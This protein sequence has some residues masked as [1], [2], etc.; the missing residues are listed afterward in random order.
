VFADL[1]SKLEN[2]FR[3]LAG[4]AAINEKN[5]A[6]ALD[7][8]RVA[9]LEADV[10]YGVVDAIITRAKEKALGQEVLRSVSPGQ[11][12]VKVL[13]DE[14]VAAF[15]GSSASVNLEGP[16]P[17]VVMVVGLQGSGK[18]TF[19][20]KLANYLT[21]KG[22]RPLL[23]AA[24]VYRP[25]AVEQLQVLGRSL[26]V[27]T[28]SP[29]EAASGDPVQICSEAVR[30][31]GRHGLDTLVLDT[32]GRLHIDDH[33]MKELD[34]IRERT[35]PQ[36]ILFVA[37]AMTGQ[38]AVVTAKTF[39]ERLKFDG[40]VLTKLDG[41]ARGGAALSIHAVTGKPIKFVGV[42]EKLDALEEFHPDRMAS[43]ILGMG[44]IV[45]LVEKAQASIDLEKA[46]ELEEKLRKAEFTLDDF[47][48]QLTQ[49]KKLGSLES[50]L[51]MIPG[52]GTKLRSLNI[53]D[54]TLLQM[55]AILSSMTILERRKPQI[56]DGRRR[57]RVA[58]GS[59]T[60][61]QDVNRLLKQFSDMQKMMKKMGKLSPAEIMRRMP[62]S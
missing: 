8:I 3:K 27:A 13:Y 56:L 54:K 36:E 15:G 49:I 47:A 4:R 29:E 31:A 26:A 44:D 51:G 41:D 37:D 52:V 6:D 19:C 58:R 12:M 50:I 42:G 30:Y 33:L 1:T 59:G 7:E 60:S 46:R 62:F 10:H 2:V 45:T 20:G 17:V 18:T 53:N 57:L 11:Q 48:E 39:A 25:A 14:L 35:K 40:V 22:R 24:D 34:L 61:V 9:L 23:V 32:A 16:P 38:D 55:G 5:I 43:R 28:F 21:R